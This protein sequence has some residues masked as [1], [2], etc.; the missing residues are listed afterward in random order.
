MKLS[1]SGQFQ[2]AVETFQQAIQLDATYADAY[3]ALGR[4]YF[5]MRKWQP[6]IDNLRRASSSGCAGKHGTEG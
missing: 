5:K 6:A 3:A 2:L 1:E 4:T